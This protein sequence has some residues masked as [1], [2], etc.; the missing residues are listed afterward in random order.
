MASSNSGSASCPA[1]G[2]P[3]ASVES[4]RCEYCGAAI[5]AHVTA[6]KLAAKQVGTATRKAWRMTWLYVAVFLGFSAFMAWRT[7]RNVEQA[8]QK[9]S[10]PTTPA[11]P[12]AAATRTVSQG[13]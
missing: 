8:V 9:A 10:G 3:I 6:A 2:A 5:N 4:E 1:C 11:R 12:D 7:Q 13:R